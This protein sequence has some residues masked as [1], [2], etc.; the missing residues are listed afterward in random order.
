M[1]L[2]IKQIFSKNTAYACM[3]IAKKLRFFSLQT[4]YNKLVAKNTLKIDP[5]LLKKSNKY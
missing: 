3:R 5:L 1:S 4:I 2:Q